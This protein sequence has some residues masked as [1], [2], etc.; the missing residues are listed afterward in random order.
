M[1]KHKETN[2]GKKTRI[3]TVAANEE[4]QAMLTGLEMFFNLRTT[5]KLLEILIL[6]ACISVAGLTDDTNHLSQRQRIGFLQLRKLAKKYRKTQSYRCLKTN[7]LKKLKREDKLIEE[8]IKAFIKEKY[9]LDL[10]TG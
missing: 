9:G 8:S 3:V 6:D 5:S 10:L 2:T 4:L 1:R 7:L